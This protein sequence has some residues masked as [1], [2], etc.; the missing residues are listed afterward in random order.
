MLSLLKSHQ[1][2]SKIF[3]T[4]KY[5]KIFRV[6]GIDISSMDKNQKESIIESY[7]RLL[8]GLTFDYQTLCISEPFDSHKHLENIKDKDEKNFIKKIIKDDNVTFKSFYLIISANEAK[9]LN[10]RH[11]ICTKLLNSCCLQYS[12][13]ENIERFDIK[14]SKIKMKPTKI[15]YVDKYSATIEILNYPFI[16]NV[17]FLSN[18][19]YLQ[20]DMTISNFVSPISSY[21]YIKVLNS[22]IDFLSTVSGIKNDNEEVTDNID[23]QLEDALDLREN[24]Y[25]NNTKV[26]YF[27]MYIT[28]RSDNEDQLNSDMRDIKAILDGHMIECRPAY[29]NHDKGFACSLPYNVNFL[30]SRQTLYNMDTKA[31]SCFF[32]FIND[33]ISDPNGVFYGVNLKN[34]CFIFFDRF[35]YENANQIILGKSGSGKG[36]TVKA[37]IIRLLMRGDT[38]IYI[39]DR[40]GEYLA[41]E[42]LFPNNKNLKIFHYE[43]NIHELNMTE[44][45]YKDIENVWRESLRNPHKCVLVIDELWDYLK[46][47]EYAILIQTIAKRCRKRFMGF[48]GLTQEVEDLLNND[49]GKSVVAC[50]SIQTIMKIHPSQKESIRNT[51]SLTIPEVMNLVSA[52]EGEGIIICGKNRVQFKTKVQEKHHLI[53]STNPNELYFK[54]V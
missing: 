29:L 34:N 54:G 24:L 10:Y 25:K 53:I 22:R 13:E 5:R 8:N 20:K 33:N 18:L 52:D 16:A 44:K 37:E 40:D 28:V 51:F 38:K 23:Q 3:D 14:E 2:Q 30:Q 45:Y 43:D 35:A 32:P 27:S 42:K 12:E 7:R 26:F 6:F 31:L 36:Y 41:L 19:Y 9:E 4:H 46:H 1:Y 39:I 47:C 11:S 50:S 48:I 17:G 49:Y 21:E 15:K